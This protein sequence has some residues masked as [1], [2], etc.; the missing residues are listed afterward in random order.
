MEGGGAPL[1]A[2]YA[3]SLSWY[4]RDMILKDFDFLWDFSDFL[5]NRPK[6]RFEGGV[7]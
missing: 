2:A 1:S 5:H 7:A 6:G 3:L 4:T